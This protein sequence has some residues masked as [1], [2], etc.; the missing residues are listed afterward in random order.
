MVNKVI[1]VK[2][3]INL[4]FDELSNKI[5]EESEKNPNYYSFNIEDIL[6][7][8][9]FKKFVFDNLNSEGILTKLT[10]EK[11]NNEIAI[12]NSLHKLKI[13]EN[14]LLETFYCVRCHK[15]PRNA[16][17][18]NCN[19]LVLCEVCIKESKICP[20]CGLNID[21]FNKIYRS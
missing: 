1:D 9:K 3:S 14:N 19:H 13:D 20:K 11:K 12:N 21:K 15:N 2:S 5:F 6:K 7:S 18:M 4:S 17:S 10:N 16:I 8:D